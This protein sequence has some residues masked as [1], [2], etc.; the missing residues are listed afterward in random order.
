MLSD[1][2][3][4]V[5]NISKCYRI[6][7]RPHDRLKQSIY[8]GRK[9]FYNEF[10]ALKDISFQIKKGETIGIIGLN[11]SGKSTL[12]Q[13]IAG[14]LTPSSGT[15]EVNGRI[16]ALLEL[17]S[18]FNPEFTGTE[19]IF[20]NGAI[21]GISQEEMK[22]HFKQIVD[23]AEIGEFID[24]PVKTYSS[25]MYVRLA[26]AVQAIVPKEILIV[27]E[28]LS[29]GD[30]KFQHKCI[31]YIKKLR[32][33]GVSILFV[34]HDMEAVKRICNYS[35]VLEKGQFIYQGSPSDVTNWYLAHISNGTDNSMASST[36]STGSIEILQQNQLAD[37]KE[38]TARECEKV[39]K[40]F[41]HGDGNARILEVKI[42]NE[43]G[44]QSD[45]VQIGKSNKISCLFQANCDLQESVV[46]F[47]IRDRLGTDI[48]G[49][50]TFQENTSIPPVKNGSKVLVEFQFPVQLRPG[51]Y[52]ITCAIAYNQ[53]E[54]KY[55]EWIDNVLVFQVVDDR[56]GRVVFGLIDPGIE[57]FVTHLDSNF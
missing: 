48:L 28:A 16:T 15:I 25:G 21:L 27:D 33:Q 37:I 3:I 1:T 8:R 45:V 17:G 40:Y 20:L 49:T 55:L 11:G 10:W 23:F 9:Q 24:Q 47:Y 30:A 32:E 42:T 14:T 54:Q 2:S 39:F 35:Y 41:R 53:Y 36:E 22:E 57:V 50:N 5:N 6:Y 51:Y 26:F 46:G 29:V 38:E 7:E 56:P 13:I 31:N 12:L 34:S 43:N 19:N 52:S 44:N 18:G 4:V